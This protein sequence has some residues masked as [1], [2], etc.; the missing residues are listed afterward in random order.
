MFLSLAD[1]ANP[2]S[3]LAPSGSR[4][5]SARTGVGCRRAST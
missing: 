3:G 2:S 5:E 1:P 4:A